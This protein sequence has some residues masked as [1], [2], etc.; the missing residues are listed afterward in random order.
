MNKEN[1][2]W[3]VLVVD[4]EPDMLAVTRMALEDYEFL[5]RHVVVH[6]A[7]S[8]EEC[9]QQ[10]DAIP[11]MAVAFLDIVMEAD[12]TGFQLIRH[13]RE[14]RHNAV[15]RLIIRTGQPGKAPLMEVVRKYDIND[16]K[17]KT[18]LTIDKL[19]VTLMTALRSF[20]QMQEIEK[21]HHILQQVVEK[22]PHLFRTHT[23]SQFS[24]TVL[25]QLPQILSLWHPNGR[26]DMFFAI[27]NRKGV[28]EVLDGTGIFTCGDGE[29]PDLSEAL[30]R[31]MRETTGVRYHQ[32]GLTMM[33]GSSLGVR[34]YV[35]VQDV[36]VIDSWHAKLLHL[37]LDSISSA[38]DN[39]LL[40][41]ET[42]ATQ[43]E[44]ILNLGELMEARSGE[45]VYH[46]H[47]VAAITKLLAEHS[48]VP[49]SEL[50]LMG[51][52]AAFHDI[53]KIVMP[54]AILNKPGPLTV[55]EFN[56]IKQHAR[57][58]RDMLS[59]SSRPLFRVA[60]IMAGQHHERYDGTGYPDGR[61]GENIHLYGRILALAD[62]FDALSHDR[63]YKRA[64]P[65]DQV[66]A[67]LMEQRGRHFD[68]ILVDLFFSLYD[69]IC[70]LLKQD[71]AH[72]SP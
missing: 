4:D 58:G 61:K 18:E 65:Q 54:E 53:G 62:V 63:V 59:K 66:L 11:E 13:I 35:H 64:W 48:G 71:W 50:E 28:L 12:D 27:E 68:P 5:G 15:I 25:S 60:S 57:I 34:G 6:G 31:E 30:S 43:R 51:L 23:L 22:N 2:F 49:A 47:R 1:G 17:E 29:Q 41:Q 56:L 26:Y 55:D 70:P 42:D 8:A 20:N 39:L 36:P 32:N 45:T 46:V 7:A 14:E 24:R 19:R 52:A 40:R 72:V 37:F 69:S 44:I 9:R 38:F 16:Y 67:Y 21:S 10:L 3:H 33:L